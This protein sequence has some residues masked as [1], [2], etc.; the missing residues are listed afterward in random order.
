MPNG[1]GLLGDP[2]SSQSAIIVPKPN[3]PTIFYVF[4][5][6][7]HSQNAPHFGLNYSEIDMSLDGGLGDVTSNKNIN[8]LKIILKIPI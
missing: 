4:T 7:D 5:V 1:S 8:L 2:S 3:N 6:D